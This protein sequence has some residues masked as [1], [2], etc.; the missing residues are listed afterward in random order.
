MIGLV[1]AA[2]DAPAQP[3]VEALNAIF[4]IYSDSEFD[5]DKSVFIDLGFE[6]HLED[7]VPKIR[8]LVIDPPP[9]GHGTPC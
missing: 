9:K 7:S 2:P 6:K 4:D 3:V 8:T 1:K 5:Y